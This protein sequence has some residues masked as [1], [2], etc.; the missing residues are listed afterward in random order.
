MDSPPLNAA[1]QYDLNYNLKEERY[2]AELWLRNHFNLAPEI[3]LSGLGNLAEDPRIKRGNAFYELGLYSQASAEF[4]AV[5]QDVQQDAV[6]TFRL[7]NH[8]LDLGF[9]R[10]AILA[11]RQILNLAQLSDA[12]TFHCT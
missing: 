9:Y 2:L 11:S 4:E 5:R 7:L 6:N 8:L 1:P 3:D 12:D 10:S